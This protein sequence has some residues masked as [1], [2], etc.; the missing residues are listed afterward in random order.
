M[1][2]ATTPW[3]APIESASCGVSVAVNDDQFGGAERLEHLDPIAP[4]AACTMITQRSRGEPPRRLG[5]RVVGGEAG[6]GEGGDVG[7]FQ[8]VI[9]LATLRA[10]VFR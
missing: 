7:R 3:A 8:R 1:P 10:D 4:Q 5:R 2:S 6:I 9:D